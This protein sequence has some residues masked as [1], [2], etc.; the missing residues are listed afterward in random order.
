MFVTPVCV[1]ADDN[2]TYIPGYGMQLGIS[3]SR[4]THI[5]AGDDGLPAAPNP[6]YP[7]KY[8]YPQRRSDIR[9]DNDKTA[10]FQLAFPFFISQRT[11]SYAYTHRS[12]SHALT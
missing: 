12:F 2:V 1:L 6:S 4:N 11:P 3:I 7:F 5:N 9:A 8:G 10:K